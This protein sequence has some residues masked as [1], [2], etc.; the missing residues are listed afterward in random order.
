MRAMLIPLLWAGSMAVRPYA[1]TISQINEKTVVDSQ[2]GN[3][4]YVDVREEY[5]NKTVSIPF[6]KASAEFLAACGLKTAETESGSIAKLV[7]R[8]TSTALDTFYAF[9]GI[10][11]LASSQYTASRVHCSILFEH[12]DYPAADSTSFTF[13]TEFPKK[14]KG[15]YRPEN[16]P[17]PVEMILDNFRVDLACTLL[18]LY[19]TQP[20]KELVAAYRMTPKFIAGINAQNSVKKH[21]FAEALNKLQPD[22]QKSGL[23]GQ[24]NVDRLFVER[25]SKDAA[26]A[27]DA[28]QTLGELRI[29]R[30]TDMLLKV[31]GSKEYRDFALDDAATQALVRIGLP[32]VEHL[33]SE[34]QSSAAIR[35]RCRAA[36]A[37]GRINDPR[38][39]PGLIVASSSGD[40]AL[41]MSC[42]AA[43][44]RLGDARA[45]SPLMNLLDDSTL[46]VKEA[47]IAALGDIKA[48]DA[49]EKLLFLLSEGGVVGSAAKTALDKI[50]PGWLQSDLLKSMASR[51]IQL[52]ADGRNSSGIRSALELIDPN[53]QRSAAAQ[54]QVPYLISKI[55]TGPPYVAANVLG[56]IADS[57]AI[58]PLILLSDAI[59][60]LNLT[61]IEALVNI[62]DA[63]MEPLIKSL[64]H[65]SPLVREQ[66]AMALGRMGDKR[67]GM[68]LV[69]LLK[70]KSTQVRKAA[71][72][73]LKTIT[74]QDFGMETKKWQE[75]IRSTAKETDL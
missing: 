11:I 54:N 69:K 25:H 1:A 19:N 41:R 48:Q 72:S 32:A 68:P 8:A 67:A 28:I 40:A 15:P 23:A 46:Y 70:D 51:F 53:W 45:V 75:Y 44:G 6:E 20:L 18:R 49:T 31:N 61:A 47:A 12:K 10:S 3:S 16:A 73:A 38:A 29:A 27:L 13:K 4:V 65:Q 36:Q 60:Y 57:R 26:V 58:E 59:G 2:T 62:G 9:M 35:I 30:A 7:I 14:I 63:A 34:L 55:K 43:L 50:E 42:A 74:Q 71:Y 17:I 39:L 66:S 33:I 56:Q 64:N 5:P 24:I 52:L 22:W 37:L 21:R